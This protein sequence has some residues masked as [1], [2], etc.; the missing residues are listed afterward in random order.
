LRRGLLIVILF[1]PGGALLLVS[2]RR[3]GAARM[4]YRIAK[5]LEKV[6]D[7]IACGGM[8]PDKKRGYRQDQNDSLK[9]ATHKCCHFALRSVV[10]NIFGA[11]LVGTPRYGVRTV[12]R[13]VPTLSNWTLDRPRG[14]PLPLLSPFLELK[15]QPNNL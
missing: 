7:R 11:F 5:P 4:R 3:R 10:F 2:A 13:A 15:P 9:Q 6:A 8:T 12:Q 14:F 1:L